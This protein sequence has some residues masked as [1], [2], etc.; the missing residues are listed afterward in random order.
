MGMYS[1][2]KTTVKVVLTTEQRGESSDQ[3][4]LVSSTLLTTEDRARVFLR[5]SLA[6]CAQSLHPNNTIV[7]IGNHT[8][9]CGSSIFFL[10][11]IMMSWFSC[12]K[13]DS[14]CSHNTLPRMEKK[15][16]VRI[17]F[18]PEW[19]QQVPSQYVPCALV[20]HFFPGWYFP[21]HRLHTNERLKS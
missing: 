2:I 21:L 7:V 5:Y 8:P 20:Y 17:A 10:A 11:L 14:K 3:E 6:Q 1:S 16:T 13:E 18:P 12:G 9:T 19:L 15:N 4:L